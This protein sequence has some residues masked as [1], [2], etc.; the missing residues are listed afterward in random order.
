MLLTWW[1]VLGIPLAWAKGSVTKQRG[2]WIGVQFQ[3]MAPGI[4]RMTLPAQYL[5][6][7]ANLVR[8]LAKGTGVLTMKTAEQI[9]GKI[10][11]LAHVVPYAR[12]HAQMMYAA[13]AA[14]KAAAQ[15][16]AKEASPS[17]VAAR[18]FV[19]LPAGY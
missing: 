12:P 10:G 15:A 14:S 11:R 16:G 17:M 7:L 4:C 13:L 5:S 19:L 2:T 6:S 9:A 1:Q 8:S 18:R 3:S